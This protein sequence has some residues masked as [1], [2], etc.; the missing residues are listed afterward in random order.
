MRIVRGIATFVAGSV[1]ASVIG[2]AVGRR[3]LAEWGSTPAERTR[4]L[5]GDDEVVVPAI[6][7]T[8]A[9]TIDAPPS[10]VS[11]WIVQL[12]TGRAGWYSYTWI[13]RLVG[14]EGKK[15]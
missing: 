1:V 11:P 2:Y 13:E 7:G 6:A 5:P 10:A 3:A 12:G 14:L 15:L 9:I 8:Q 4:P